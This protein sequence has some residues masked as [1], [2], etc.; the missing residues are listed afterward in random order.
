MGKKIKEDAPAQELVT[1]QENQPTELELIMH[2]IDKFGKEGA[3]AAVTIIRELK[4]MKRDQERWDA[5]KE[6]NNALAEFQDNCPSIK[7]TS[8]ANVTTKSG[9][10]YSYKYAELDGIMRTVKPLLFHRGFSITW[11]S[12]TDNKE[13]TT[14]CFLRHRNGHEVTADATAPIPETLAAMN[15]IQIPSAT[16]TYLERQTLIQVLGLTITDDDNDGADPTTISAEQA[17]DLQK[18]VKSVG[19]NEDKFLKFMDVKQFTEIRQGDL[20]SALITIRQAELTMEI[21]GKKKPKPKPKK[22]AEQKAPEDIKKPDGPTQIRRRLQAVYKDC[23]D[24]NLITKEGWDVPINQAIEKG[25][26]KLMDQQ[27][28]SLT[29]FLDNAGD[30]K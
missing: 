30:A 22:P 3:E 19:M 1:I 21:R 18:K 6:C 9:S 7:R 4:A 14:T 25:D 23:L 20:R 15:K 11:D 10:N 2:T 17:I 28:S 29:D 13:I 8:I 24:K 27:I 16:R 26:L 5:K 12:K